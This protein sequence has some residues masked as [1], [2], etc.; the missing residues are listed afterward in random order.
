MNVT[1]HPWGERG[2]A[3]SPKANGPQIL[4]GNVVP[5]GKWA[6]VLRGNVN[7]SM[8]NLPQVPWGKHSCSK[9]IGPKHG[10]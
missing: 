10:S 2:L 4:Q 5:Q 6:Q 7:C 3:T 9:Q 1:L 8:E